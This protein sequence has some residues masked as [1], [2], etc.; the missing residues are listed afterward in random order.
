[1]LH[2]D[3]VVF[4]LL[5]CKIYLRGQ[6]LKQYS[7][8][9]TG[10]HHLIRG[11]DDTSGKQAEGDWGGLADALK[12]KFPK[13]FSGIHQKIASTSIEGWVESPN[14]EDNIPTFIDENAD[15]C[16]ELKMI[17]NL[18]IVAMPLLLLI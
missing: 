1:M 8:I 7:A 15:V 6:G 17:Y 12:E 9:E 5:L 14:P 18:L 10:F 2:D 11:D 3:R 13:Y 16:E 4:A